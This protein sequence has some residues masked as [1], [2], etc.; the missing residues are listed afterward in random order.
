MTAYQKGFTLTEILVGITL[1]I[2]IFWGIFGAYRLG[3]KTVGMSKNKI[4]ATTIANQYIENIHNLSY[5]QVGTKNAALP[6]ASGILDENTAKQSNDVTYAIE[7]KVRYISD[8]TDG[9]G[10]AD[11]C[12]LDYKK[13]EIT[14]SWSGSFTGSISLSTNISSKNQ[15]EEIQA[16]Q[17]QPGGVLTVTIFDDSGVL[18]PSPN[19]FVYDPATDNLIASATPAG[20]KY[21]FPLAAGTY[22]VEVSKTDY[23]SSR[24]YGTDEI[25][26]PD[27]P[28]PAVL[29]GG[30][31]PKSLSI[32]PASSILADGISPNGQDNFSDTFNDQSKISGLNNVE[33]FLSNLELSGP[34]YLSSGYAVSS[35]V[36]PVNLVAWNELR[37]DDTRPVAT[38]VFY[39]ILHYDGVNWILVPD[40][41]LGGNSAGFKSSP[42]NLAGLDKSAYPQIKIEAVL[43]TSD[44]NTTPAI[45]NWQVIW[46]TNEGV[47]VSGTTFHTQ[48]A[49]TI[50]KDALGQKIYK[51][52]QDLA[53]NDQGHLDVTGIDSDAYAFSVDPI[54][55]F[56]LIGTNPSSPVNAPA[57]ASVEVKLFLRSQSALLVTTQNDASLAPVFSASVRLVNVGVGY[58][59]TQYTDQKGQTYFAPLENGNYEIFISAS[60]FD[61]YSGQVLV[62]GVNSQVINIHQQ[63]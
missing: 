14:V 63:E 15:V 33:V 1:V 45:H 62:S 54:S 31:T 29:V 48:G 18:V 21:S 49:K 4:V 43:S 46:T 55:G 53:L 40:S 19:I 30:E 28:N 41:D 23:S 59:K 26:V 47:P 12:N 37:F 25:A 27:N 11:P 17:S 52:S 50:G 8:P 51:Y 36:A 2:I 7:T 39:Q 57:G 34:P 38:D 22:R 5:Q 42:V 58:D 13:V 56:S 16:C 60:G 61:D 44:S 24:T 32:N 9:I 10:E 20:G 35:A 6:Y 3:L